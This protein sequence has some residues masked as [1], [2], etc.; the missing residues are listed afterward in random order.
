MPA[1]VFTL[2]EAASVGKTEDALKAEGADYRSIKHYYRANGKAVAMNETEGM[3][4]LLTDD[5]GKVVGC[6]VYGAHAADL[7]QE[8]S[9]LMCQDITVEELDDITHIHP[10]LSEI[11]VG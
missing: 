2:P 1:A 7:V 3:L 4:K 5:G 9:A 6:H 11:I 8:V 10:T